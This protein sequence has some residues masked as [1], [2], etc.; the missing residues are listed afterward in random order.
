MPR[1]T[2]DDAAGGAIVKRRCATAGFGGSR[3][4]RRGSSCTVPRAVLHRGFSRPAPRYAGPDTTMY[5]ATQRGV[6]R[7]TA[8]CV[9]PRSVVSGTPAA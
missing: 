8:W 7:L 4:G 9:P 3:R 6:C 5:A 1:R 2:Q